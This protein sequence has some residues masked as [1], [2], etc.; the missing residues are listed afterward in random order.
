MMKMKKFELLTVFIP[1]MQPNT[2]GKWIIDKKNDGS[3]EHPIQMPFVDY[4]ETIDK[5]ID[6]L[7][8]FCE[9]HPEYEHT[10]Y[11][12]TL[13]SHGLEWG[14]TSME[15]ADVTGMDA[16]GVIALLIG[17]V[18]AERFCDGALLSMLEKG[19]IL[20]WLNR[21]EQIDNE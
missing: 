11:H 2:Y 20:R 14:Q 3:K 16:K 6:T 9:S 8:E 18:R 21:L 17:A 4:S 12:A 10:N 15:A 5:F 7:Y 19:C 1:Q 13:E